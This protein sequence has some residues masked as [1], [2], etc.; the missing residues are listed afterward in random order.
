M[1]QP[2]DE[3]KRI[4]REALDAWDADNNCRVGKILKALAGLQPGYRA[5][6][7]ALHAAMGQ[8]NVLVVHGETA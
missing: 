7:D 1:A 2:L 3:L 4:A 5:D 8:R 6:I